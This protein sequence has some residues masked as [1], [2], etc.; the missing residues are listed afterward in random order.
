MKQI[1]FLK[2]FF[3]LC[4]LIVGSTR[5]WA[6]KTPV[7]TFIIDFYDEDAISSSSGSNLTSS[8]YATFV[9]VPEGITATSVV[10]AASVTGTV[11]YGKNG[12][13]TM[14]TNSNTSPDNHKVTF[15]I[16][17]DYKVKKCTVYAVK[18]DNA[19]RIL[20]NGSAAP[21]G[22]MADKSTHLEDIDNPLIWT[23]STGLTSLEFSRDNGNGGNC[24][25]GTIYRIVCEYDAITDF[26]LTY[27][28][29][30]AAAGT[31]SV[32]NGANERA[33]QS[34]ENI[35]AAVAH[36]SGARRSVAVTFSVGAKIFLGRISFRRV[37]VNRHAV[38]KFFLR[39]SHLSDSA[40]VFFQVNHSPQRIFFI[41]SCA[42]YSTGGNSIL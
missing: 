10:T 6:T 7:G 5:V 39:A 8:N 17:S 16:A 2:S 31:I 1:T 42:E 40:F 23:S 12:G 9:Q 28:A 38:K 24:K 19:S 26:A 41:L 14:G 33:E 27:A 25:R 30:P 37:G 36:V 15:T 20:L 21:T 18:Y 11:Q 22:S 32:K 34:R 29:S 35:R 3:L 4:A 13:L